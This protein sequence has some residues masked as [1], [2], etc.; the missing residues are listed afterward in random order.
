MVSPEDFLNYVAAVN[1]PI[2]RGKRKGEYYA[3]VPIVLD[4]ETSSFMYGGKKTA[5]CYIVQI[6][7]MNA[8]TFLRRIEELP[9]FIE[10]M[11]NRM[12]IPEDVIRV[13]W[14]H[15]LP[16]DISFFH[17]EFVWDDTFFLD[18]GVPLHMKTG[19]VMFRDSLKL[20][21]NRSLATIAKEM[22]KPTQKQ[23][24]LLDYSKIRLP[25]TP[26]TLDEIKYS[27]YDCYCL[28]DYIQDKIDSDGDIAHIPN[29]NTGYVRQSV[30]DYCR[31]AGKSY[32]RK[33]RNLVMN[34]ANYKMLREA[35]QGGAVHANAIYVGK[36]MENVRSRDFASS[37][38][39]RIVKDYF[40]MSTFRDYNG[41]YGFDEISYLMKKYCVLAQ[42]VIHGLVPTSDAYE[43]SI[44]L[45]KCQYTK[46]VTTNNGRVVS[47]ETLVT[48]LT[49]L[50]FETLLQLYD[51]DNI[52]FVKIQYAVR[53]RM[54]KPI[55]QATLE[56]Y[57][58]K[59]TLKGVKGYELEYMISKNMLNSVY[60]MMVTNPIREVFQYSETEFCSVVKQ[61]KEDMDAALMKYNNSKSRF[62][63]YAWGV[64]ITAHSR[65]ALYRAIIML[66]KDY[67][68]CDT[69]SVKYLDPK[70]QY[71]K[72]FDNEDE[73]VLEELKSSSKHYRLPLD[74]YLPTNPKGQV[75]PMGVW[76]DEGTYKRFKTL[77]AKRYMTETADGIMVTLS[78]VNKAAVTK[79]MSKQPDPFAMFSHG[80]KLPAEACKR[81]YA[82]R[83]EYEMEGVIEDYL[84]NQCYFHAYSGYHLAPEDYEISLSR[85]FLKYLDYIGN[86]VYGGVQYG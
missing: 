9:E 74:W 82:S 61:S 59:T 21:G 24:G 37:Y 63:F 13:I 5:I 48:T 86:K 15:N 12:N 56:Y 69:D 39:A 67:V 32:Y 55:V 2:V 16:Y 47:A 81:N 75:C 36:V 26:L 40:P 44:S 71:D 11:M 53:G 42:V 14:I 7:F 30:K 8:V 35:F 34:P 18:K 33:V 85:D 80:V 1:I 64:W 76:S 3:N 52:D 49:E 10:L 84:G 72:W 68:Y 62:L 46:N 38:P 31:K 19:N 51:F 27:V 66:G 65:N 79:Y 23:V 54:P 28:L 17:H 43:N 25:D 77:G 4:T 73:Q 78:G 58:K 29:T 60:G 22:G 70:Q 50:D 41:S 6:G 83:I 45:S 57:R 20:S